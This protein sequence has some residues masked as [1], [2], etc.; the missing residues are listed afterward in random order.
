VY[1]NLCQSADPARRD[2]AIQTIVA[3]SELDFSAPGQATMSYPEDMVRL[4]IELGLFEPALEV[5]RSNLDYYSHIVLTTA[6]SMRSANGL[7]FYCDP[8]V[9]SLFETTGIPPAEG[10]NTCD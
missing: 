1:L 4:L 9:Q 10:K 7:R 3:W 5:A 6:R 8:R 2:A